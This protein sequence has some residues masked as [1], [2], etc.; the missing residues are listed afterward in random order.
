MKLPEFDT[1]DFGAPVLKCGN[2]GGSYIRHLRVDVYERHDDATSGLHVIVS[3]GRASFDH[4]LTGN[5]S[6]RREGMTITF[7]CEMCPEKSILSIAQH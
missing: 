7:A 4:D 1:Q 6:E 2:C 5:P 3:N